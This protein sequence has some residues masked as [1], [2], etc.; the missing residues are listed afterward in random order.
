MRLRPD[1]SLR[2][3]FERKRV[4]IIVP[5]QDDELFLCGTIIGLLKGDYQNVF[6]AFTTNGDYGCSFDMRRKESISALGVYG[7]KSTNIFFLGYGDQYNT[8]YGHLYH[9]PV[10]SVVSSKAG[11]QSTYGDVFCMRTEGRHH[12]YTIEN[13]SDDF[14][15]IIK[16]IFPDVIFCN[17]LDWHP[18]HRI[19]SLVFDK[20]LGKILKEVNNY[21]P[22]VFKGFVYYLGW[23]GVIDYKKKNLDRTKRPNR[24]HSADK[25]FEF[26]NPYFKW[27]ERICFPVDYRLTLKKRNVLYKAIHQYH[28]SD[29]AM[30]FYDS[31]MNSDAIFWERSTIDYAVQASII[32]SSGCSKYLNDFVIIDSS[33]ITKKNNM[34]FDESIWRAD[35]WDKEPEIKLVFDKPIDAHEIVLYRDI[36]SYSCEC[37]NTDIIVTCDEN[38]V[39]KILRFDGVIEK[40]DVKKIYRINTKKIESIM[41]RMHNNRIGLSE[42]EV[43]RH[44]S[45]KFIKILVN[46]NF[47]YEYY[48]DEDCKELS[49]DYY[50][51]GCSKNKLVKNVLYTYPKSEDV[52]WEDEQ[53]IMTKKLKKCILKISLEDQPEIYDVVCLRR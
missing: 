43:N 39:N 22:Y 25:R 10:G 5:H 13:Y 14:E 51:Y 37:S 47:A 46:N 28:F 4:L 53:I 34:P 1:N 16:H 44:Q 29:N 38:G 27:K 21:H 11:Y 48:V 32:I 20:V 9:A 35:E 6:V 49:V 12:D 3:F 26:G 8:E 45:L 19:T 33:N 24:Y 23:D 42:I 50:T 30:R 40:F 17:D 36:D 15:N 2:C 18:E 7:I 52:I 31:M 41:I